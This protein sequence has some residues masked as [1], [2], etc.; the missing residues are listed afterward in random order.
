MLLPTSLQGLAFLHREGKYNGS[1]IFKALSWLI[2]DDEFKTFEEL[3]WRTHLASQHEVDAK[4]AT[5]NGI[6]Q[7]VLVTQ[8]AAVG[9]KTKLEEVTSKLDAV[10]NT[11]TTSAADIAEC[12]RE[13]Q[14]LKKEIHDMRINAACS[15]VPNAPYATPGVVIQLYVAVKKPC[16]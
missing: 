2:D 15:S 5:L 16:L 14:E 4:Q 9:A 7:A 6:L 1:P 13:M 10:A 12:M 8:Q 3:V 11:A